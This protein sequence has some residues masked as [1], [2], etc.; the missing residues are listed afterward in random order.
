LKGAG[1]QPIL[2]EQTT[3]H[4]INATQ[5]NIVTLDQDRNSFLLDDSPDMSRNLPML[6]AMLLQLG[7]IILRS[8]NP[9][10]HLGIVN[11]L[12]NLERESL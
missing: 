9:H 10:L 8:K 11:S 3:S 1:I 6:Q 5:R 7:K 2:S 12:D 4:D